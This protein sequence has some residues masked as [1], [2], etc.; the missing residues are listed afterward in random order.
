MAEA[1]TAFRARL[2]EIRQKAIATRIEKRSEQVKE[3]ALQDL[4]A[5]ACHARALVAVADMSNDPKAVAQGVF[6]KLSQDA[7]F[8]DAGVTLQQ[9]YDLSIE[10]RM[11]PDTNVKSATKQ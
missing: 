9:E 1:G 11:A 2:F 8:A 3:N 7:F 5:K 6:D 10:F 4:E